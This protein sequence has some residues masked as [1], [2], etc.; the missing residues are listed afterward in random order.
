MMSVIVGMG[1]IFKKGT[2]AIGGLTSIKGLEITADTIDST[3]LDATGGYR[4]FVGSLKDAGEVSLEGYFD[5]SQHEQFLTD[6]EAGTSGAYSIEFTDGTTT[7]STWA[8]SGV[9]TNVGT[10]AGLEDL[11]SFTCTIK[12]SGQPTFTAGV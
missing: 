11:V 1:T 12:V 7:G 6:L 4:T 10:E 3:V 8:F 5:P 9:V 2:T